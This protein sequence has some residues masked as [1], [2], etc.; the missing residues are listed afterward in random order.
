MYVT[1]E[2]YQELS[3]S[4][5]TEEEYSQLAPIADLVT[6]DWTLERVGKAVK[7][8]EE[9]PNSVITLYCGIIDTLPSIIKASRSEGV[10][11]SSFSNGIDSYSF[12]TDK[13][14]Q[15][16]LMNSVGWMLDLLPIEWCSRAVF[17]KGGND[18]AG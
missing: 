1:Y 11:V 12:V 14:V 6:D 18:Y 17:F 7:N 15:D 2:Q 3:N 13:T 9:L 5:I 4:K 10:T 8:D 16:E